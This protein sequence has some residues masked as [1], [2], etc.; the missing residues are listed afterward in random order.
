MVDAYS[1]FTKIYG[2][3]DK[4]TESVIKTIRQYTADCGSV[5]EFGYI[6]IEMIRSDAGNQFTS[7]EFQEFCRDERINLSLAAPKKQAQ[8]HFAEC[9]WQTANNMAH[10]VIVHAHLPGS[11]LYHAIRYA[12]AAFNILPVKGLVNK[13]GKSATPAELLRF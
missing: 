9:T 3:D 2:L 4:T 13:D 6:D 7:K 11:F 1:R 5:D 8:N 12:S 10:S